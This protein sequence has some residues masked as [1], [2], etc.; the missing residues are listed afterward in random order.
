ME[1]AQLIYTMLSNRKISDIVDAV[2]DGSVLIL[3]RFQPERLLVLEQCAEALRSDGWIP[4]IFNFEKPGSRTTQ[5]TVEMLASLVRHVLADVT[6]CKSVLQ[7]L[8]GFVPDS[9]SV[10]VQPII[11]KEQEEPGMW[12]F[13]KRYPWFRETVAYG[14]ADE[15]VRRLNDGLLAHT[16]AIG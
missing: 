7:E 9:P 4:I 15:L 12:D 1:V 13:F 5:E 3:G 8:R 14:D 6:D 16:R 11:L 10:T 2:A